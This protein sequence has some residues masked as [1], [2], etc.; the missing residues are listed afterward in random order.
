MSS[1]SSPTAISTTTKEPIALARYSREKADERWRIHLMNNESKYNEEGVKAA[2]ESMFRILFPN[3]SEYAIVQTK[4]QYK[5]LFT[6]K[7]IGSMDAHVKAAYFI[8]H[9]IRRKL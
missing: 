5:C 3:G 4:T 8:R 2:R 6:A 7:R 9:I 1:L